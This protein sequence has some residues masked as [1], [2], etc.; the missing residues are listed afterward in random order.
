QSPPCLHPTAATTYYWF[1]SHSVAANNTPSSSSCRQPPS[2]ARHPY[3]TLF[4]SQLPAAATVGANF[5]DKATLSGLF[6]TP[7]GGSVSWKLYANNKCEGEALASEGPVAVG[8]DGD[9]ETPH[10]SSPSAAGS[11]YWV[12][13]YSGDANNKAASSGC[14]DEPITVG[15]ASPGIETTQLPAAATVGANFKDKA[16][17]SGLFGTPPGGSVSW[18]LYANNKCEGE[19]LASEGPVAVGKDGDYETPHGS[20]PSAAG[21]YYWV[22]SYSGDA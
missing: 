7:P 14:G 6:G 2:T 21:S 11:Y 20:S 22:A 9:Y 16:T 13:S 4:R 10:G 1:P 3:P 18:K 12:A 19:A 8:K 5:K 17:L 15:Q